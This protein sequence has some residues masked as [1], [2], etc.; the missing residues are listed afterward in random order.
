[1]ET[2]SPL[3]IFAALRPQQERLLEICEKKFKLK[4][5]MINGGVSSKRRFE[6]DQDFRDG[7]LDVVVASPATAGVG[8]NWGRVDKMIFMSVDPIDSSFVQGYRRA[9]RGKR[10]TPLLIYLMEYEN[11]MD[12]RMFE[13]IDTK[14]KLANDVDPSKKRLDLRRT[15]KRGP[16]M[17]CDLT[18][19]TGHQPDTVFR[20]LERPP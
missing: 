5:G 4:T 17:R 15:G 11:S 16:N 7:K 2:K 12:Q 1:V 20:E 14:S 18:K 8:F 10:E 9:V 19:Q 6:I 3:V 13:I